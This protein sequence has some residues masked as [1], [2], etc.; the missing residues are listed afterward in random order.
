MVFGSVVTDD[1]VGLYNIVA[2]AADILLLTVLC[3]WVQAESPAAAEVGKHPPSLKKT[4]KTQ[5]VFLVCKTL[6]IC[7]MMI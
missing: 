1:S 6:G 2:A 4:C 5:L 3:V 7:H